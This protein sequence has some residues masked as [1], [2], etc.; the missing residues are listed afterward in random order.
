M[1]RACPRAAAHDC[2]C[3]TLGEKPKINGVPVSNG[4]P[5]PYQPLT[6]Y[7]LAAALPL[8]MMIGPCAVASGPS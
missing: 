4:P 1:R 2:T 6:R 3:A 5:S 8:A 7:W